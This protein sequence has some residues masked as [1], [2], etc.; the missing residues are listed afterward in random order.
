MT[1]MV[2]MVSNYPFVYSGKN[3]TFCY[4]RVNNDRIIIYRWTV[5]LNVFG[6]HVV[7]DIN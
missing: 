5:S 3:Y 4:L 6:Q 2:T 7:S 1:D